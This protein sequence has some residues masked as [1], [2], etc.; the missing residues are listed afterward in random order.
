VYDLLPFKWQVYD[1]CRDVVTGRTGGQRLARPKGWDLV[2]FIGG[3]VVFF[4]SAVANGNARPQLLGES[5]GPDT[6][7]VEEAA[8]PL[9]R[10]R[11]EV[12]PCLIV[13]IMTIWFAISTD[14]FSSF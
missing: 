9:L 11:R 5:Y 6:S 7:N 2:I 8:F 3:K 13:R 1:D 12:H 14:V 10:Q 4:S